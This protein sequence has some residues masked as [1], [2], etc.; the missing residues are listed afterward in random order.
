VSAPDT[1][2]DEA[3]QSWLERHLAEAPP[4]DSAQQDLIVRLFKH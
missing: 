4:L 1:T 3:R 2:V